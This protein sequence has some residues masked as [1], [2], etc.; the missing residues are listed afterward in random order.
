VDNVSV[1][2]GLIARI[3]KGSSLRAQQQLKDGAWLPHKLDAEAQGR[4][5]LFRTFRTRYAVKFWGFKLG[6]APTS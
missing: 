5:L 4:T 2:W 6:A 3:W 1:G